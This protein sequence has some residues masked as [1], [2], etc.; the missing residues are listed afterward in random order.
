MGASILEQ[1]IEILIGGLKSIGAGIGEA[2]SSM[3]ESIFIV[4]TTADGGA[5]TTS[6]STFGSLI[7]VFAGISLGLA[8]TRWV[9]NFITSL[10]NRNR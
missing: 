9:L 1:I 10:G 5:T 2:L 3:A 6:L 7:I 8:L 4:K